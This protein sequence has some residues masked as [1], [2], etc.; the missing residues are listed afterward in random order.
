[1][2]QSA[3]KSRVVQWLTLMCFVRET[4]AI[5]EAVAA[6]AVLESLLGSVE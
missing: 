2:K 3:A 1:M 6:G 5:R 4:V